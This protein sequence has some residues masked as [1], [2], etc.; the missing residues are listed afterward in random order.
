[1]QRHWE[2]IGKPKPEQLKVQ[3]PILSYDGEDALEW[4]T[5]IDG[6]H[7]PRPVY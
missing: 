3:I 2:Y 7:L 5:N 1:M 4:V 6:Q